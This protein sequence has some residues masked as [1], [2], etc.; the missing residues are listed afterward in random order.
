MAE[1]FNQPSTRRRKLSVYEEAQSCAPQH[2]VIV[3]T[4]R[5]LQD[6]CDVFGF[7]VG[8]VGRD[9]VPRGASGEQIEDILH[10]NHQLPTY[11]AAG[12]R[13]RSSDSRVSKGASG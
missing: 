3:L 8:I 13:D 9:L 5:K 2:R 10:T 12:F 11:L 1:R 6:G 7:E 4:G